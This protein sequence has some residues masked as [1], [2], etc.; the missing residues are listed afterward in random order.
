MSSKADSMVPKIGRTLYG[1]SAQLALDI[2]SGKLQGGEALGTIHEVEDINYASNETVKP[3]RSYCRRKVMLV[4]NMS[5]VTLFGKRLVR[6]KVSGLS[7]L[8]EIDGYSQNIDEKYTY[9]LD[10]FLSAT[11]GLPNRDCGWIVI[12]GPAIV[13]TPLAGDATNVFTDGQLV[14]A[15]TGSTT[16]GTTSG[17]VYGLDETATNL[18][19]AAMHNA[20]GR[21]MSAKTTANTNAELLINVQRHH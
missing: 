7:C 18:S 8:A 3:Y 16:S 20:L 14:G 6:L 2:A 13:L 12:E 19:V 5:G 17:R 11:T 9:P 1:G 4:R 15:V 21:A 10:E